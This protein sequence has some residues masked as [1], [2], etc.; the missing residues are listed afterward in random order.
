MKYNFT[1]SIYF[2]FF[3]NNINWTAFAAITPMFI[4]FFTRVTKESEFYLRETEK[5]MEGSVTILKKAGNNCIEW[6][7]AINS[8]KTAVKLSKKLTDRSHKYIFLMRYYNIAYEIVDI[9]NKT[10]DDPRIY[11]G[12]QDYKEKDIVLLHNEARLC[13]LGDPSYRIDPYSIASLWLFLYRADQIHFVLNHSS[14]W[15]EAYN[16]LQRN[17]TIDELRSFKS[18]IMYKI[19]WSKPLTNYLERWWSDERYFFDNILSNNKY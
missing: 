8:L 11:Y 4:W 5:F 16:W 17:I 19:G 9:L 6:H 13:K 15:D 12:V 1:D 2:F 10:G 3:K 18:M 14:S 7:L